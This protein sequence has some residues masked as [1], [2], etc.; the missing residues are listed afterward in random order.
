MLALPPLGLYIHIPWCVRKCPYCDFN[1]HR[2]PTALP[3]ADYVDALLRDLAL[4]APLLQSRPVDSIFIGGGTPSLFSA[5]AIA[6]LMRGVGN[7]VT[8]APKA[9]ITLEANP[10][11]VEAERFAAFRR[12]G[13]NR[14]SLGIQSFSDAALQRLGRIHDAQQARVAVAVARDAGFDNINLDLMHGLPGQ[15]E[16]Q[17]LADLEEGLSLAPEH[18]S[19]YQLTL[20]PN[21]EFYRRPPTLPDDDTVHEIQAAGQGLLA[22]AGYGRYEV[23]AYGRPGRESRHNLNYWQFGDYLGIGAGAH[24]KITDLKGGAFYRLRKY[25]QPDHY[26]QQSINFTAERLTVAAHDLPL[27]FLL[28]AFRLTGGF[29][30]SLFEARTGLAFG[31]IGKRIEYLAGKGLLTWRGGH[32]APTTEGQLFVNNLLE[33][34]L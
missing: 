27:E 19:W 34:F 12:T 9:E 2:A 28:N 17:A 20:E 1:S 5:E 21:T 13:I 15:S 4:D 32:V 25:R 11:T 24:G 14:L 8:I 3:E 6:S 29:H 10:G 16:A 7:L 33:E 18:L 23:S 22:A 26:R 31:S 30:Q